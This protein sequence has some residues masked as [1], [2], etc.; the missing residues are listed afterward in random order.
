MTFPR[1]LRPRLAAFATVFAATGAHAWSDN[2]VSYRYGTRFAEPYGAS[3]IRKHILGFTHA[4]GYDGGTQYLSADLLLSD[5][6]DPDR[7]GSSSG[8][9]EIYL[10]YRH[11][12]DLA[13]WRGSEIRFGPFR[14]AGLTAGFDLN[15]KRDAGYNSR[16]R[17]LVLGPTLMFDVPGFA[18]LSALMLWESNAPYNDFSG[19]STS[20]YRYDAHPMLNLAW[21]IPF[22]GGPWSFTGYAN[23]IASKGRNEFGGPTAP[24]TNIDAQ[25]M[26]TPPTL[27]GWKFG[28]Q[29]QY[30]RN[31]FGN[32][33]QG[34]AG[35]GAFAKTPMLR[36]E[37][38]F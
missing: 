30:W 9:R 15:T 28:F 8:A 18:N 19:I 2:A 4:S 22:A 35:D 31:K 26:Y 27:K 5:D 38:H 24:E 1:S 32:P 10:L 25:V 33:H 37:F 3:D 11:T 20:R 21:G 36:A 7:A 16:K 17:M 14:G 23:F 13:K 34:P 29:Y 12:W 6:R